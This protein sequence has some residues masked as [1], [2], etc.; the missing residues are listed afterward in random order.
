MYDDFFLI[1]HLPIFAG[2]Q[3]LGPRVNG[4]LGDFLWVIWQLCDLGGLLGGYSGDIGHHLMGIEWESLD[5]A[6]VFTMR[7][8]PTGSFCPRQK[9]NL[10]C[11]QK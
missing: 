4:H 10:F 7:W 2:S 3:G 8:E 11:T 6:T 5:M 9:F 1:G